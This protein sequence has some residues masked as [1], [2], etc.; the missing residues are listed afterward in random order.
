MRGGYFGSVY[1]RRLASW[2]LSTNPCRPNSA[3]MLCSS[4]AYPVCP[5][6]SPPGCC[7]C[8]SYAYS[9][10]PSCSCSYSCSYSCS[11]PCSCSRS[12]SESEGGARQAAP[13]SVAAA[14]ALTLK[15]PHW[16]ADVGGRKRTTLSVTWRDS[17]P[18]ARRRQC[19]LSPA[20]GGHAGGGGSWV[21]PC[22]APWLRRSL[23]RLARTGAAN[24]G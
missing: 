2:W 11:S 7:C 13:G 9:C 23:G 18:F 19:A 16:S 3:R 1:A 20:R 4:G 14:G 17:A 12:C 21:A 15:S 6:S 5:T 22:N 8:C 10:S 24:W